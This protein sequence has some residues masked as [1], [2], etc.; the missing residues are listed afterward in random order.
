MDEEK[1]Y[2]YFCGSQIIDRTPKNNGIPIISGDSYIECPLCGKYHFTPKVKL[3]FA[4]YRNETAYF[5]Y[6]HNRFDSENNDN[7]KYVKLEKSNKSNEITSKLHDLSS[8]SFIYKY[9]DEIINFYP[10]KFS[11]KI[12]NCI[13]AL[14]K[15]AK[16]PGNK[17]SLSLQELSIICCSEKSYSEDKVSDYGNKQI[18]SILTYLQHNKL[19]SSKPHLQNGINEYDIEPEMWL[20]V[21]ELEKS[22]KNNK[23]VF[24]AMKF[25]ED[26]Q[27]IREAIK[28]GL[29]DSG[30]KSI[31]MDEEIHGNQIIPYM[32]KMMRDS[33]F[34]I[35]E[36]TLPN[37]GAY[38]EAGYAEGL[39]KQVIVC[40]KKEAFDRQINNTDPQKEKSIHFD[41][42]QKQLLIW[43]DLNDLTKQLK[44]WIEALF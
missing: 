26:T 16:L 6:H 13:L 10:Q 20:K 5:L 41:I 8:S 39:G 40:C 9:L 11:E 28:Q 14:S 18:L 35:M 3:E 36:S 30:F 33:R 42:A 37:M 24:I 17:A 32:L 19:I 1:E 29:K 21:E 34:L 23:N 25:H 31:L 43:K 4:E 12:D 27:K 38:F 15:N 22:D 44:E 7:K 2:C